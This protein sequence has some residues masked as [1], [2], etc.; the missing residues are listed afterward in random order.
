MERMRPADSTVCLSSAEGFIVAFLVHSVCQC[1]SEF[2]EAECNA[3][4]LRSLKAREAVCT[5]SPRDT[6]SR[7]LRAVPTMSD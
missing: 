3:G 1:C 7:C 4:V 6:S 5:V 2:S